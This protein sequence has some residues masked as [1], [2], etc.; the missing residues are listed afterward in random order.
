LPKITQLV[1]SLESKPGVLAK[2]CRTLA[3]ANVNMTALCAPETTGRAKV[4]FLVADLPRAKEALK[5]A[6][7]E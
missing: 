2:L 6:K 3:D 4:R 5:A 7:Y 1:V